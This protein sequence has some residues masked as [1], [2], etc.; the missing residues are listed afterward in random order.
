MAGK[1]SIIE[2]PKLQYSPKA[3]G[4][5]INFSIWS[6]FP[7]KIKYVRK[8]PVTWGSMVVFAGYSGPLHH[9]KRASHDLPKSLCSWMKKRMDKNEARILITICPI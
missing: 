3:V 9:F 8:L 2:I 1:V 5:A 6:R 4:L 7:Q